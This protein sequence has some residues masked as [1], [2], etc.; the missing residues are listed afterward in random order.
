[1]RLTRRLL[2]GMVAAAPIAALGCSKGTEGAEG[3]QA[4]VPADEKAM[5]GKA[6]EQMKQQEAQKKAQMKGMGGGSGPAKGG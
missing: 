6:Y 4:S 3:E 2:L 1:M 5:M